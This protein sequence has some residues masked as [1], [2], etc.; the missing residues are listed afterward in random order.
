MKPTLKLYIVLT[1][2]II[3]LGLVVQFG[4]H[5]KEYTMNCIMILLGVVWNAYWITIIVTNR[6]R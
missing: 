4:L 1:L 5:I 2:I 3:C 6:H